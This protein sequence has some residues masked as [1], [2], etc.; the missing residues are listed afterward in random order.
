MGPRPS[1]IPVTLTLSLSL[2]FE[3]LQP[4]FLGLLWSMALVASLPSS[5]SLDELTSF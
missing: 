4:S 5:M 3:L 2:Q 1:W